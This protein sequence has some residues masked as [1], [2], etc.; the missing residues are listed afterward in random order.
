MS[1][2]AKLIIAIILAG[3]AVLHFIADGA[4]SHAPAAPRTED[5][6]PLPNRD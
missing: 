5:G 2:N 1:F 6:M 4:L 3:F